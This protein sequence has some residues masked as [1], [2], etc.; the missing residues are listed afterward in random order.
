MLA[1]MQNSTAYTFIECSQTSMVEVCTCGLQCISA[2]AIGDEGLTF[3]PLHIRFLST[4][5]YSRAQYTSVMLLFVENEQGN[6][7]P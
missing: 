3:Q 7:G 1:A 2:G 4:F 5:F 6:T